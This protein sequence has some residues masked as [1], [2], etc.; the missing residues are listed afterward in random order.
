MEEKKISGG[1]KSI[2]TSINWERNGVI[3][4]LQWSLEIFDFEVYSWFQKFCIWVS[5]ICQK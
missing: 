5:N 1:P 2:S 4:L 3:V